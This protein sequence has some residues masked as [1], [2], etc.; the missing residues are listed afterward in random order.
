MGHHQAAR[1][2]P[3]R[4]LRVVRHHR[5]LLALHHQL[6][7]R[8]RRDRRPR[9]RLHRRRLSRTP[10]RTQHIDVARRPRLG[11]DIQTGLA[12]ARR[13]RRRTI[14]QPTPRLERQPVLRSPVQDPQVLPG[15]PRPVRHWPPGL[16]SV[17]LGPVS[18]VSS[19][20]VRRPSNERQPGTCNDLD[21]CYVG[22]TR[23]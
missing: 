23:P 22:T 4:V 12:T 19:W 21:S 6:V 3:G 10:N 13:S 11:N 14:P 2:E 18:G 17:T 1:A 20:H 9:Q 7:R 16:C 8:S 5:H 15:V